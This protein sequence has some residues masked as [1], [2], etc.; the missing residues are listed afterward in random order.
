MFQ[1]SSISSL[2]RK[3]FLFSLTTQNNT[4]PDISEKQLKMSCKNSL[5]I[6]WYFASEF[7]CIFFTSKWPI[8]GNIRMYDILSQFHNL[9]YWKYWR[10]TWSCYSSLILF[11]L[12]TLIQYHWFGKTNQVNSGF[13]VH[14]FHGVYF[15]HLVLYTNLL[16]LRIFFNYSIRN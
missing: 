3:Y 7:F 8:I 12:V 2:P 15:M 6:Q 13:L 10:F 4:F 14:F 11:V 5:L 16:D 9:K 1:K